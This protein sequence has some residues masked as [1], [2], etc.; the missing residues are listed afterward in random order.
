VVGAAALAHVRADPLLPQE[1]CPPGWP[2]RDLR[3]AYVA[4]Q[5]EFGE[6]VRAWFRTDM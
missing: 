1:L 3:A 6:A 5:R 4:Y 2:G